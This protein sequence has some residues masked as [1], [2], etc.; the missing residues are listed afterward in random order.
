MAIGTDSTVIFWGT[1]DDLDSASAAV[2]NNAFS[3]ATDLDQTWT[4]DDDAPMAAIA[5]LFTF[6]TAPTAGT[7][8]DLYCRPLNFVDSTKDHGTTT[9]E[10]ESL[11][12]LGSFVMSNTEGTAEQVRHLDVKL[13]MH[14]TAQPMEFYIHN[15]GTGQSLSSGW[16]LQI[17]PYTYGPHA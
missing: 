15:N 10:E 3:I 6:G 8:I 14:K 4:N 2:A 1:Q 7:T 11:I 16:S 9:I 17:T 5:G 13:P 12:Y